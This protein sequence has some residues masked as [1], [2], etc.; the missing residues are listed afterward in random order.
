MFEVKV[1]TAAE[2]TAIF[3]SIAQGLQAGID[4][5]EIVSA[6][7]LAKAE[8]VA[9]K[10]LAIFAAIKSAVETFGALR[11]YKGVASEAFAALGVDFSSAVTWLTAF[12]GFGDKIAELA[13]VF[14]ESMDKAGEAITAGLEKLRQVAQLAAAALAGVTTFLAGPGGAGF[15]SSF[16]LAPSYVTSPQGAPPDRV[17]QGD[18]PILQIGS[19]NISSLTDEERRVLA[20]FIR[21][22]GGAEADAFSFSG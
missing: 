4:L 12:V 15:S 20:D 5:S 1:P 11:D 14:R 16:T 8:S 21:V 22:F 10:S 19:I 18:R 13:E 3:A 7:A 9:L 17:S 6:E 2:I